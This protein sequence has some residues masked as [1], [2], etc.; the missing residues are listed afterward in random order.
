MFIKRV[1][2]ERGVDTKDRE[3]HHILE[4]VERHGSRGL[5]LFAPRFGDYFMVQDLQGYV[6]FGHRREHYKDIIKLKKM[7]RKNWLASRA[8][9]FWRWCDALALSPDNRY[10]M[11]H[12]GVEQKW[13]N[14]EEQCK[15]LYLAVLHRSDL[16]VR[17]Q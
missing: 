12:D 1:S 11:L 14:Y 10:S 13:L 17:P 3:I 4:T 8:L 6:V 2:Y 15:A 7:W 16:N 5:R 9:T